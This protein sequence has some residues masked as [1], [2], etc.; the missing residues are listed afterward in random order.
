MSEQDVYA[1]AAQMGLDMDEIG[2]ASELCAVMLQSFVALIDEG[3]FDVAQKLFDDMMTAGRI[4]GRTRDAFF[5]AQAVEETEESFGGLL[6]QQVH[7]AA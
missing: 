5:A 7:F 3:Q 2:D 1:M 6:A 4:A